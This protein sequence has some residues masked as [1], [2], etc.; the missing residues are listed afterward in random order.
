MSTAVTLIR[1]VDR[2]RNTSERASARGTVITVII[3]AYKTNRLDLRE[4]AGEPTSRATVKR[5]GEREKGVSLCHDA[6][7]VAGALLHRVWVSEGGGVS[8]RAI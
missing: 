4:R 3:R 6:A 1:R 2:S 5:G 7:A 8:D